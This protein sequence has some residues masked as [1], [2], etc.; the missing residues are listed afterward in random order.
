MEGK[1]STLAYP[2]KGIKRDWN[3]VR[4]VR[5]DKGRALALRDEPGDISK[6]NL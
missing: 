4:A 3:K 1:G 6:G 2:R 5:A